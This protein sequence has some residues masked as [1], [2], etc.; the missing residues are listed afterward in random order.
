MAVVNAKATHLGV[1]FYEIVGV[2]AF[3]VSVCVPA[4]MS[5]NWGTVHA[6]WR[7]ALCS[8]PVA[9]QVSGRLKWLTRIAD[10]CSLRLQGESSG[11]ELQK[12]RVLSDVP[13]RSVLLRPE[14]EFAVQCLCQLIGA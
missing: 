7:T 3:S 11:W 8:G 4:S 9:E 10:W 6:C 13:G 1:A 12:H 2:S 5:P 14:R